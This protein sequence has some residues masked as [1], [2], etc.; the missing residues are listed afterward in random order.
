[1]TKVRWLGLILLV[2][3]LVAALAGCPGR[4]PAKTN[5][6]APDFRATALDGKTV[7]LAGFKGKVLVVN[8]F[9][10]WCPPCKAE[11]PD[12]V[13]AYRELKDQG[14]EILGVNPD[15]DPS[16]VRAFV[17]EQGINYPVIAGDR[18]MAGKFGT[19][20]TIPVTIVIDRNGN[21]VGKANGMLTRAKLDNLV[22]P[23]LASGGEQGQGERP[24]AA[25]AA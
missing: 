6:A 25:G 10:T 11:I 1:M 3:L 16:D 9:A 18:E 19:V 13:A 8:Y 24:S 20:R 4:A 14:L 15:E 7:S 17:Q 22:R 21:V 12:F 2:G 23:L 5:S